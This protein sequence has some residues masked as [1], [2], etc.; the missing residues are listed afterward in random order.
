M[1]I[2]SWEQLESVLKQNILTAMDTVVAPKVKK[3]ES[4]NIEKIVYGAYT[5]KE[6]VRRRNGGGLSDV[7]NM[8]H[9][10]DLIGSSVFIKFYFRG[11]YNF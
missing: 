6:Y 4:E 1:D 2:T 8:W 10:A 9:N 5:P 11:Y 7:R 3:L